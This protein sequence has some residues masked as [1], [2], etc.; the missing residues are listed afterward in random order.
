VG[1]ANNS[2]ATSPIA[3][4]SRLVFIAAR[5]KPSAP[6]GH[7]GQADICSTNCL[8]KHRGLFTTQSSG[9]AHAF[10]IHEDYVSAICLCYRLMVCTLGLRCTIGIHV[11]RT[12]ARRRNN[13][14]LGYFR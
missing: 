1:A 5:G 9:G 3:A 8:T 13:P 4:H 6:C 12:Q 2:E 11:R 14:G 7:A 10:C